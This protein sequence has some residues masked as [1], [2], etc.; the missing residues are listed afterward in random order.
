MAVPAT[1]SI[2]LDVP[3]LLDVRRPNGVASR[4]YVQVP[5]SIPVVEMPVVGRFRKGADLQVEYRGRDGMP[6][7]ALIDPSS[8]SGRTPDAVAGRI[9]VLLQ[10]RFL[11]HLGHEHALTG[12]PVRNYGVPVGRWG[13]LD[14]FD[15]SAAEPHV[16]LA[17][18]AASRSFAGCGGEI[19][20]ATPFP[21]WRTGPVANA[22]ALDD[23]SIDSSAFVINGQF[24]IRRLEA[25]IAYVEAVHGGAAPRIHGTVESIDP[26]YD[27]VDDLAPLAAALASRITEE[28]GSEVVDL[29]RDLVGAFHDVDATRRAVGVADRDRAV[30]VLSAIVRLR[31]WIDS[32]GGAGAPGHGRLEREWRNC[33]IR[34]LQV[35]G[36]VPLLGPAAPAPGGCR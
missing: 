25:A 1:A 18:R 15:L 31:D 6:F 5:I 29:P 27:R 16:E 23:R 33:R 12:E 13:G 22:V 9:G 8:Q 17:R 3:L 24:G 20:V 7:R 21:V 10:S 26:E 36:I 19:Q 34:L 35:E 2:E 32:P 14:G 11:P 30:E 28:L 4:S